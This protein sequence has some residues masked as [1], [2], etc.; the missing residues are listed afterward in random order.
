MADNKEYYYIRLRE[1]F[2]ESNEIVLLESMQ[3][4]YLYSNILL[5]LYLRSLKD[6]GKLMFND[7]IPY[8]AQMIATI[9]RHQ[10]GTVEKALQLFKDMGIIDIL[11]SGAIYMLDIQ[12]FIGR[13]TTE[14]DRKREYRQKIE[15]EKT[16]VRQISDK[17]TPEIEKRRV[18]EDIKIEI[19]KRDRIDYQQIVDM[20]N[21][22]CV[23]FPHVKS[24]SESRKKAIR[25]RL[26][27]YSLDDIQTLFTKAESN[28]FLKGKNN[29]NWSANFDWL[30][31]DSSMAKVLD[32]NYEDKKPTEQNPQPKTEKTQEEL[33]REKYNGYTLAELAEFNGGTI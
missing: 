15:E 33:E 24:L 32:G 19:E 2:F 10:V 27:T 18:K 6:N 25:A 22:T 12:T 7:R 1:N 17:T 30:L 5:K 26:K 23:S 21:N 3:D 20:Y 8:N 29:R 4:G 13:T 16:N 9:T 11:P 28:D 14:A 31:K